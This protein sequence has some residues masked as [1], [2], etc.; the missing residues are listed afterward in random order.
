MVAPVVFLCTASVLLNQVSRNEPAGEGTMRGVVYGSKIG[1]TGPKTF[2]T[3]YHKTPPS[4][5]SIRAW[6][7]QF[8]ETGNVLHKKGTGRSRVSGE[9][10]ERIRRIFVLSPLSRHELQHVSC[11]Y[12]IRP[13]VGCYES[14]YACML[15][16]CKWY[17]QLRLMIG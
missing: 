13:Y 17:K 14:V 2:R 12:R 16:S 1:Y 15:T 4:R 8:K 9:N 5:P 7:K 6:Y 10:V 11:K 3:T